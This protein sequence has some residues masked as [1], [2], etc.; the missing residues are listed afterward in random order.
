MM[1][2]GRVD[3]G[4]R[5]TLGQLAEPS[6]GGGGDRRVEEHAHP[7]HAFGRKRNPAGI[8]GAARTTAGGSEKG[9][10]WIR[11]AAL[12]ARLEVRGVPGDPEQFELER[13]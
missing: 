11:R 1:L 6:G 9:H 8:A 3:D 13:V 12:D 7:V 10:E 5:V 4:E 2:V